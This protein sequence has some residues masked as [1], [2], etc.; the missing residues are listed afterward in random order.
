[1]IDISRNYKKILSGK[2]R[3]LVQRKGILKTR[4]IHFQEFKLR[5]GNFVNS[6]FLLNISRFNGSRNFTRNFLPKI[7]R[8]RQRQ[9]F[10]RRVYRKRKSDS[11]LA[12][13]DSNQVANENDL[14]TVSLAINFNPVTESNKM[15]VRPV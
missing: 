1:M 5:R 3:E 15:A 9:T 7:I 14:H 12:H 10:H 2:A 13:I 11:E 4:L 8:P 6:R